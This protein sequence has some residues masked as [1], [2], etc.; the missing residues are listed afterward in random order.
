MI[1][2]KSRYAAAFNKRTDHLKS[3]IEFPPFSGLIF[4]MS[5]KIKKALIF[6]EHK[7]IVIKNRLFF[8]IFHGSM[9]KRAW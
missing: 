3:F 1:Q 8:S 4:I 7:I 9:L 6:S 5:E 2:I